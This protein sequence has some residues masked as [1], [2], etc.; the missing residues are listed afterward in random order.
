MEVD[1]KERKKEKLTALSVSNKS[2]VYFANV[3]N[4]RRKFRHFV[5]NLRL[6]PERNLQAQQF[7]IRR[8]AFSFAC[9]YD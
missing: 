6:R 7:H 4:N 3:G 9:K 2:G 5:W 1:T 8:I